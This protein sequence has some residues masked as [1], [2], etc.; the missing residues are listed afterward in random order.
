[1]ALEYRHFTD[2]DTEAWK[3]SNKL[4]RCYVA[5]SVR[6]GLNPDYAAAD[7]SAHDS[8]EP[9]LLTCRTGGEVRTCSSV[10]QAVWETG[11]VVAILLGGAPSRGPERCDGEATLW[12]HGRVVAHPENHGLLASDWYSEEGP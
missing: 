8:P 6:V 10:P 2:E 7:H 4:T 1:M 11:T 5:G 12:P 3:I 9:W